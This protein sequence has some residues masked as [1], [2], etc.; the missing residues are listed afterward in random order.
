MNLELIFFQNAQNDKVISE[1]SFVLGR[2]S[3]LGFPPVPINVFNSI[4]PGKNI[5]Y[6]IFSCD[7]SLSEDGG[8]SC[9]RLSE[10]EALKKA[11]SP[12]YEDASSGSC[13]FR[14]IENAQQH[15]VWLEDAYHVAK[16]L[17]TLKHMGFNRVYIPEDNYSLP[18][19]KRL[20]S[21]YGNSI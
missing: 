11:N 17:I 6:R 20:L 4:P 2:E 19:A 12:I 3:K 21:A 13:Y 15:T 10:T 8:F 5:V 1:N 16:K 7:F 14:Y 9:T 18:T